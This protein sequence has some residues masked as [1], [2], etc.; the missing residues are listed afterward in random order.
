MNE[1]YSLKFLDF[2]RPLFRLFQIDYETM[3]KI[4]QIKLTMDQRRIPTIFASNMSKNKEKGNQYLKSLLVYAL[5]GLVI[6]PFVSLGDNYIFLVSIIF[7][8]AMFILMT[9]MISD[10]S[11]VLLDVRDKTIL[12]T[13]PVHTRTINAA[14]IVHVMIYMAL[15]TGAFI[16]IPSA[17]ILGVQGIAFFLL[18][19]VAILLLLMFIMTLTALVYIFILQFFSGEKLKDIINYVQILLSV[20]II[21][22]YQIVVRS[23]EFVDLNFVY[24]FSWWHLFI[25]PIWFGAPFELL[26][27]G[28]HSGPIILLSV[29][30]LIGPLLSIMLYYKL[31]PSFE[32]NLQKLMENNGSN[33]KK[34][35]L[36]NTIWE[37]LICTSKEEKQFF[38]FASIMLARERDFKLRVYPSLGIAFVF[39]F[40]FLF[41][42]ISTGSFSELQQSNMH[43]TMYFCNVMIGIVVFMLRFSGKYKG[44]WI[45]QTSPIQTQ[46]L[47]YSATLKAVLA[48]LYVPLFLLL[49]I[50][51]IGIFSVRIVPDLAV[52]LVTGILHTLI[53]YRIMTHNKYPFSEP[54][55][56]GQ[57][58]GE[59][60]KTFLLLI[61]VGFFFFGHFLAMKFTF[62]VLIY[63]VILLAITFFTWKWIFKKTVE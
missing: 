58:G 6:I 55:E 45:F 30:A 61:V 20:G 53:S 38:R 63:L 17:F 49:S 4:L 23:F 57:Q 14:K 13:K 34:R 1:F 2:F 19:I 41:N 39:P 3:R 25:P 26:L 22:G 40:I 56:T 27:N 11:T 46:S 24:E 31:M 43:L 62:G 16:G 48:K 9:S 52:M 47:V 29:L 44:A 59:S 32:R 12:N 54:F 8:I 51:Y 5:Y 7:G 37:K 21:I 60:M 50:I 15:L 36:L 35:L 42:F 10:F 28:N 18:F 33:K